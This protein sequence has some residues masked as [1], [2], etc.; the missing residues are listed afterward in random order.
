MV[1]PRHKRM[2]TTI[3]C[4]AMARPNFRLETALNHEPAC[5][6]EIEFKQARS[7][8]LQVALIDD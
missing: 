4:S 1:I 2:A 3:S 8:M 5:E 6:A 7:L